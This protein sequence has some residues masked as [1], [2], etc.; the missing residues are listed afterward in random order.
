MVCSNCGAQNQDDADKCV[1]CGTTLAKP[2]PQPAPE[3]PRA[4]PQVPAP[5]APHAVEPPSEP[6]PPNYL[7]WAI[8]STLFCCW[9]TGI[10]AIVFAAQVSS[11]MQAGDLDG[12][13][14]A[15]SNAKMWTWITAGLGL[16][17][18]VIALLFALVGAA[19]GF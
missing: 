5:P 8:L 15:S 4:R 9:P 3:A 11:K 6:T 10:V 19:S 1:I 16:A 7:V 14:R 18:L 12:A 2:P 13:R 17:G